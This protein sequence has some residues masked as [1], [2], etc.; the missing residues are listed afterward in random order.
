LTLKIVGLI[1]KK[2]AVPR[3]SMI[4]PSA[5]LKRNTGRIARSGFTV[6]KRAVRAP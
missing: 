6:L 4:L 2:N 5:V 3:L 1:E